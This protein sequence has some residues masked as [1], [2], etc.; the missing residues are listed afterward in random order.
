M[1]ASSFQVG[2]KLTPPYELL[3]GIYQFD[4]APGKNLHITGDEDQILA[5]RVWCGECS[6]RDPV[7]KPN[8]T[9]ANSLKSE[10]AYQMGGQAVHIPHKN[11]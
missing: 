1:F 5:Q 9:G 7:P 3:S 8:Q 10:T 2:A 4:L 6:C 11:K